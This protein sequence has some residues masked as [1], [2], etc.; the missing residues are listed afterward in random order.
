MVLCQGGGG[1]TNHCGLL[2]PYNTR[3]YSSL[4]TVNLHHAAA[5]STW[6]LIRRIRSTTRHLFDS[7]SVIGY[8]LCW[9][10]NPWWPLVSRFEDGC[11]STLCLINT[12]L[13]VSHLS[14]CLQPVFILPDAA[15]L[16]T[17]VSSVVKHLIWILLYSYLGISITN[18]GSVYYTT[19]LHHTF[20]R[21]SL[22]KCHDLT[23]GSWWESM[24]T[25]C[26]NTLNDLIP[27]EYFTHHV[28]C[29]TGSH[30]PCRHC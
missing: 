2:P 9:Y 26:P 19:K 25:K 14:S 18:T 1:V 3:L 12:I 20:L 16:L 15:A 8:N 4:P 22:W 10:G 5:S 29:H 17:D 27:S 13:C 7:Q 6:K 28:P 11:S 23:P 21:N 24:L 30:T